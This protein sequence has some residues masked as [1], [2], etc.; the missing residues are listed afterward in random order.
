MYGEAQRLGFDACPWLVFFVDLS[1][2]SGC[3]Y[4]HGARALIDEHVYRLKSIRVA[5]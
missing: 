2:G 3:F 5:E 4:V 1:L